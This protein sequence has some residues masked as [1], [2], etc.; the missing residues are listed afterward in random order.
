[1][2][3]LKTW[4]FFR[5]CE[6]VALEQ[7]NNN[8]LIPVREHHGDGARLFIDVTRWESTSG[9]NWSFFYFYFYM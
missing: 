4:S 7:H 1:M 9:I 8:L 2:E 6:D 3:V 5:A